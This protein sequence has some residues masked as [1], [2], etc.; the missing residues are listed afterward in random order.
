MKC[1]FA[2]NPWGE[3]CQTID[4]NYLVGL[5]RAFCFFDIDRMNS[6]PLPFAGSGFAA[7]A[8]A[9]TMSSSTPGC[10]SVAADSSLTKRF[11]AATAEQ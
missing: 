8:I 9:A 7:C 4:V 5:R 10:T 11:C 6:L 3:R 1:E 2:Q